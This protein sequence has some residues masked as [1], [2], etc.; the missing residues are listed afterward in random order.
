[1]KF[2]GILLVL[3]GVVAIA[4]AREVMNYS[5]VNTLRGI[6]GGVAALGVVLFLVA[7]QKGKKGKS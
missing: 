7:L 1:M 3:L 2:V 6:G 4:V 5:E